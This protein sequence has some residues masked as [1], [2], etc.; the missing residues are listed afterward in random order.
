MSPSN[1][2]SLSFNGVYSRLCSLTTSNAGPSYYLIVPPSFF[3][4]GHTYQVSFNFNPAVSTNA[5][6]CN[7]ALYLCGVDDSS[8]GIKIFY[9]KKDALSS[10]S[11]FT[12]SFSI[13]DSFNGL[14]LYL[15]LRCY[16]SSG[17]NFTYDFSQ[18]VFKDSN[19]VPSDWESPEVPSLNDPDMAEQISDWEGYNSELLNFDYFGE[20]SKLYRGLRGFLGI[21]SGFYQTLESHVDWLIALI[22]FALLIGILQNLTHIIPYNNLFNSSDDV[23]P[24]KE[25]VLFDSN[26]GWRYHLMRWRK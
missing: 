24:V 14:N 19:P 11:S 23:S 6:T 7:L 5:S 3:L 8:I 20:N 21:F 12:F 26:Y 4:V 22:G 1:Q 16:R 17:S 10:R 25:H 15:E 9:L 18:L 2:F 13:P